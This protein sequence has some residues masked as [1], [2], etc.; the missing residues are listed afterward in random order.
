MTSKSKSTTDEIKQIVMDMAI[1]YHHKANANVT[2][3]EL[4]DMV[5]KATKQ[6]EARVTK[7]VLKAKQSL[8]QTILNEYA[9]QYQQHLQQPT[10]KTPYTIFHKIINN[11]L[12][13]GDK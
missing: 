7:E 11:E 2:L 10:A 1:N 4:M 6:I 13:K 9:N 8:A 3:G 5:D 12:L